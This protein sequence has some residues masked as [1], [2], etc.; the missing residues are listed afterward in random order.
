MN[1]FIR[2]C[3]LGICLSFMVAASAGAYQFRIAE[4]EIERGGVSFFRDT[5]SDGAPPPSA[6]N[7]PS[8]NPASYLMQGTMG[9]ENL[10]GNDK[11]ILDES[12]AAFNLGLLGNTPNL[13]QRATLNTNIDSANTTNGLKRNFAFTVVGAFDLIVPGLG[14]AYGV[15]LNDQVGSGLGSDIVDLRVRN[16]SGTPIIQFR[17]TDQ[18]GNTQVA[19]ELPVDFG[20]DQ[21]ILALDH[22]DPNTDTIFGRFLYVDGGVDGPL[23][24][25]AS[26]FDIFQ[27]EL[28]TR[29]SFGANRLIPQAGP[30]P[31]TLALLGFGLIGLLARSRRRARH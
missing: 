8:G 4:F 3:A 26:T 14:E 29:G 25:F 22:P 13:F 27:G 18:I 10:G 24:S 5:F 19:F 28:F 7:F 20:H 16:V 12:G 1:T 11:L 21:I 15:R 9:P 2:N 6:P 23:K 31:G 17:K 30:E